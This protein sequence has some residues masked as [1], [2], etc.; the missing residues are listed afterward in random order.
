LAEQLKIAIRRATPADWPA[1]VDINDSAF[2][3]PRESALIGALER[4]GRPVISL[5]A[6]A[7]GV[8]AGHIFFSL[9]RIQS[10]GPPI[11][12]AAL[13]P[14]AVSPRFQRRGVGSQLVD[15]GLRD[16]VNQA[17]Q[18]VVVVGH[19]H[20]YRRFGFTPATGVGLASVYS[21]AGDAFMAL[22]LTAGVLRGRTGVVEYPDE[23]ASV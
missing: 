17:Y 23:F 8:P 15:A 22:E 14:M 20:F 12:V 19:P 21:D 13:A 3:G 2:E 18:V 7:D 5:V 10:P 11:P 6:L 16:C 4:S 9:I 1:I